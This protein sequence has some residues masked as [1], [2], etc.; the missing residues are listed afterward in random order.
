MQGR[1]DACSGIQR[2]CA[3]QS[4]V[5][6]LCDAWRGDL[7]ALRRHGRSSRSGGGRSKWEESGSVRLDSS[8]FN[9]LDLLVHNSRKM[10]AFRDLS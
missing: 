8:V 7:D 3:G 6:S 9:Y 4:D 1:V 2:L 10:I 5:I